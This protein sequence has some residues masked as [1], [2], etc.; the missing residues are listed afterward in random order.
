MIDILPVRL[1]SNWAFKLLCKTPLKTS[2]VDI[3]AIIIIMQSNIT[4]N[5]SAFLITNSCCPKYSTILKKSNPELYIDWVIA[6][7]KV[8]IRIN[9]IAPNKPIAKAFKKDLKPVYIPSFLI[10]CFFKHRK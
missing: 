8:S 3:I 7:E 9:P 2:S 10:L 1:F 4:H 5:R 6:V